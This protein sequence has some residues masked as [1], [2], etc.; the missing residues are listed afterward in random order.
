MLMILIYQKRKYTKRKKHPLK[1]LRKLHH[2]KFLELSNFLKQ[3]YFKKVFNLNIFIF[4]NF[5]NLSFTNIQNI[6]SIVQDIDAN[7]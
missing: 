2:K 1:F 6:L 5:Q 3:D 4:A 7:Y